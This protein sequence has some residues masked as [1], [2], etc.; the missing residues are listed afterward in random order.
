M[1]GKEIR[2][3]RLGERLTQAEAAQRLG[4]SQEFLSMVEDGRKAVP[5]SWTKA[6]RTPLALARG[7]AR[8]GPYKDGL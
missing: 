2:Q 8:R 7:S 1:T 3:W 4:V 6:I 5:A